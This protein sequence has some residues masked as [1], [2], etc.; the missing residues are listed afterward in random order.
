MKIYNDTFNNNGPF[1]ANACVGNNGYPGIHTYARGYASAANLLLEKVIENEGKDFYVDTYVY[2]ICFNMRHSVELYLKSAALKITSL[3]KNRKINISSFDLKGSHDISNIWEY[4]K[5]HAIKFDKR[6]EKNINELDQY[7]ID[8]AEIDATGQVFRYPFDTENIKHLVDVNLI[9]LISL[10]KRWNELK[11]ILD[12]LEFTLSHL[13]K[14]YSWNQ[15]TKKLSRAQLGMIAATLP[16][17]LDWGKDSF[18]EIKEQIRKNYN[19]SKNDLSKAIEKIKSNRELTALFDESEPIG[20]ESKDIL[21]FLDCWHENFEAHPIQ[22]NSKNE[23]ILLNA[24]PPDIEEIKYRAIKINELSRRICLQLD[25]KS[26][27]KIEAL[28][29]FWIDYSK[30][31]KN[32]DTYLNDCLESSINNTKNREIYLN[33]VNYLIRKSLLFENIL[34]S[35]NFLGQKRLVQEIIMHFNIEKYRDEILLSSKRELLN[36]I[37]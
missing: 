32:F 4:I 20:I 3:Y 25:V 17:L 15:F 12:E 33:Q 22:S 13:A 14:E 7:I 10:K 35:L 37:N 16:P 30:S 2:P 26:F 18:D 24:K 34:N 29:Y 21:Y 27:A 1:W 28:Y 6:L 5:N 9:N 19:L 31:S 8:I 11:L 23:A 36:I